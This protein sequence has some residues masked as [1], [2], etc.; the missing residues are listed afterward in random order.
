MLDGD[1]VRRCAD[2]LPHD[3]IPLRILVVG[4]RQPDDFGDDEIL[5]RDPGRTLSLFRSGKA[6]RIVALASFGR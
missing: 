2:N 5:V 6:G 3:A 1:F 4:G